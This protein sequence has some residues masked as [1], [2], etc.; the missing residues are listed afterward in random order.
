M[1]INAPPLDDDVPRIFSIGNVCHGIF[2][3]GLFV[4]YVCIVW[5]YHH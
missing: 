2:G 5:A 4:L 1:W 3:A